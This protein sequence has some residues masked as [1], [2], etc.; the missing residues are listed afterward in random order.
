ME[1]GKVKVKFCTG[2]VKETD[3]R[4]TNLRSSKRS[5][6]MFS[7]VRPSRS[8]VSLSQ[9]VPELQGEPEEISK[10]KVREAYKQVGSW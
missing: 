3:S 4:Q 2:N 7:S 10:E 1:S 5:P 8:I 9:S 6:R